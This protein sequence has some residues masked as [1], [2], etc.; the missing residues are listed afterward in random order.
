MCPSDLAIW[1][2]IEASR[3]ART[4]PRWG[5][6]GQHDDVVERPWIGAGAVQKHPR[7]RHQGAGL[8]HRIPEVPANQSD[9][10]RQRTPMRRRSGGSPV[11]LRSAS[12]IDGLR[13]TER[14]RE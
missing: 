10:M 3:I 2:S 14:T 12:T 11:A 8:P 7:E 4:D 5:R 1:R 9:E 13:A 6:S